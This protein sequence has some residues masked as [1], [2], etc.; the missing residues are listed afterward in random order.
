MVPNELS[1]SAK[2]LL[3]DDMVRRIRRD[4]YQTNVYGLR[5]G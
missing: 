1:E 4:S 5:S 2:I 3:D